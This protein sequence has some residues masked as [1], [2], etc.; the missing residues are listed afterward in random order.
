ML[1]REKL[2]EKCRRQG[3]KITPQRLAIFDA[4]HNNNNHPTA[5][6]LYKEISRKYPTITLTTVYK[7][8]DMLINMGEIVSLDINPERKHFD[9]RTELHHHIIC[10]KCKQI[11]DVFEVESEIKPPKEIENKFVLKGYHID[12]YGICQKCRDR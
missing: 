8:L 9:P 2:V 10:E 3:F 6:M 5:E 1:D 7:T 12:F 4:L 11:M